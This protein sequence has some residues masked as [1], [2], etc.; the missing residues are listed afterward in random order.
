M[1]DTSGNYTLR[2][3]ALYGDKR[4]PSVAVPL[5]L[6]AQPI[7]NPPVIPPFIVEPGTKSNNSWFFTAILVLFILSLI[8]GILIIVLLLRMRKR[9]KAA[10][11]EARP[12]P[13]PVQQYPQEPATAKPQTVD[14]EIIAEASAVVSQGPATEQEVSDLIAH[15]SFLIKEGAAKGK[16][17]ETPNNLLRLAESF[18]R[19][20]E[21]EK[22]RTYA[23]KAKQMVQEILKS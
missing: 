19:S 11:Q 21:L 20:H 6:K 4:T 10:E 5:S 18:E 12:V 9:D 3:S 13:A 1:N 15:T 23:Y 8:I 14:P 2:V 7:P 17:I 22:A 16:N